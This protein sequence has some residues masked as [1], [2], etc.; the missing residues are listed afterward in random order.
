MAAVGVMGA[1][2][3]LAAEADH[4]NQKRQLDEHEHAARQPQNQIE[5]LVD[6]R[7][8]CGDA[9]RQPNACLRLTES[10]GQ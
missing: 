4:E 7:R 6:K 10:V 8:G 1:A 5:E 9:L 2:V 3:G